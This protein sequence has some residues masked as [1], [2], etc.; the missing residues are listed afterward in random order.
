[1]K[2]M[3]SVELEESGSK[4]WWKGDKGKYSTV[5][6]VRR[7]TQILKSPSDSKG[8]TLKMPFKANSA[9]LILLPRWCSG[10]ESACQCRSCK[11][12]RFNSLVRKSSWSRKRQPTPVFLPGKFQGQRSLVGYRPAG[13][14][15]VRHD[16][17]A[18]T[19]H[20]V[21]KVN[22]LCQ[23]LLGLSKHSYFLLSLLGWA[24]QSI[25]EINNTT[26]LK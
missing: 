16:S 3:V 20:L 15:R 17:C 2:E 18:H 26:T 23:G 14:Q 21:G 4:D 11:R 19:H 12:C 13:S 9:L 7:A 22:K 8:K 1:M 24:H 10:K 6:L 5:Y 25:K